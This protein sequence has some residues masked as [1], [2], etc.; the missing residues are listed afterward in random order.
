MLTPK[1][2]EV[3]ATYESK[4]GSPF[5]VTAIGENEVAWMRPD[6]R[7]F[8]MTSMRAFVSR[9]VRRIRKRRPKSRQEHQC[10]NR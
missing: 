2:I 7:S 9:M 5:Q 8:G 6:D 3:G 4:G 1:D 10:G